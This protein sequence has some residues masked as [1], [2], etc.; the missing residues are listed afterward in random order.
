MIRLKVGLFQKDLALRFGLSE[1]TISRVFTSWINLMYIELKDLC[2]MPDCESSEKAKQFG[3]FPMVRVIL[4]CT[5]IYTEKP[6]SLQANKAIYSHYK[7]HNTFKYLVGISPHPAVVYVSRAWGGRA[8]DKHITSQRQ[9]LIDA[10]KLGE[11]VMVDRGFAIESIL[12]PRSVELVIPDFKGQG[13]SQL[14]EIEGK[15]SEKIAEARIHVERA[16]QRI[17]MYHILGNEF[18]LSMA[19][20]AIQIFTVCAFLVNFQTSFLK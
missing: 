19:H 13:R 11:Q 5:E 6:S 3:R 15:M 17:K 10:L 16:M 20:L 2:E 14:T 7:S 4:D 18:K 12:L 1:A 9:D 8:S